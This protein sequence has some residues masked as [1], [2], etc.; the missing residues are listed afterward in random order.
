M[1]KHKYIDKAIAQHSNTPPDLLKKLFRYFPI[2]VLTN[3]SLDLLLLEQPNFLKQLY[4]SFPDI[5]ERKNIE[6]PDFFI[7]WAVNQQ[8]DIRA[9]VGRSHKI[10]AQFLEKLVNDDDCKTIANLIFSR[11]N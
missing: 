3:S 10:P 5:F 9:C 1:V 7:E 6:I 8:E 11:I 4:D 2:Q